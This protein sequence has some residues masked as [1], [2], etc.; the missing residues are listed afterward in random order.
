MTT[1]D[2]ALAARVGQALVSTHDYRRAIE[3]CRTALRGVPPG[4]SS[5]APLRR[6][7]GKLCM[8]LRRYVPSTEYQSSQT[9]EAHGCCKLYMKLRSY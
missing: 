1:G 2:T 7:L 9:S 3:H 4:Y 8:K 5:A 6:D